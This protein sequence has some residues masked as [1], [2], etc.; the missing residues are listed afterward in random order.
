MPIIRVNAES[1]TCRLHG[2]AQ[3]I[4][5]LLRRLGSNPGP[6]IIM[7]HGY[8]YQP[9]DRVHCPHRHILSLAPQTQPWVAPSWPRGF[10]FDGNTPD[11]GL[12]IAF[13][14]SARGTLWRAQRSALA[15]GHALA[16][17]ID[18]LHRHLPERP[19]H[20]AAHSMGIQVAAEALH[21]LPA[22]AVDRIVSMTGASY[23]SQIAEALDTQAGR[24][25]SFVNI[26]SRENDVF[27]FLFERL[28]AS[29][30]R[31]DRTL[32]QGL[33]MQNAVTLQLDCPATL[34]HLMHMGV[35][36]SPPTRR[37][38]HW[39]SYLRPGVLQF[40]CKLVRHPDTYSLH[41]L[42]AGLPAQSA[43][44]WSRLLARPLVARSQP[45]APKVS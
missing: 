5:S 21:R 14:W 42:R 30:E 7:I 10:G 33:E 15:A 25:V 6:V 29:P 27:D 1:E 39:S 12:G 19:V 28:I 8:S 22:G 18:T 2:S 36:I 26:T 20:I 13:G 4:P 40:Y 11:E 45:F 31:A 44:R 34:E 37:I 43:P 16:G 3:S 35:P 38:C 23:R 17:L 32:G 24:K 41:R 9:G